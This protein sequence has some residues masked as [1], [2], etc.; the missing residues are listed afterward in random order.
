MK[1]FSERFREQLEG[2]PGV[3]VITEEDYRE[4]QDEAFKAGQES[5][6]GILKMVTSPQTIEYLVRRV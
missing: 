4:I 6:D 2:H 1:T 5:R 3:V